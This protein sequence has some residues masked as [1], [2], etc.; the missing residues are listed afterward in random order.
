M[1]PM[2]GGSTE[3]K[4]WRGGIGPSRGGGVE[5]T[6]DVL[7]VAYFRWKGDRAKGKTGCLPLREVGGKGWIF[8]FP[9][10][11]NVAAGGKS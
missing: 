4:V 9:S 11:E 5:E 7:S 10:R 2:G 3:G 8:F 6:L 1:R